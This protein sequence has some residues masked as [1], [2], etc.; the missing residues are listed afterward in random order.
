MQFGPFAFQ[1]SFTLLYVTYFFAG[2]GVGAY[3][4]ERGLLASDG[5]LARRWA[6]WLASAL[7]GFLLWIIPAALTMQPP[8]ANVP[9]LEILADFGLVVSCATACFALAAVFLRFAAARSAVV[10]SLSANAYGIY[11]VHYV[12]VIWLQYLLLGVALFAIAKGAI[13]FAA[14]SLLSWASTAAVCRIPIGARLMRA[15]GGAFA[16]A[17]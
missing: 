1:P 15:R 8:G 16:R 11:L 12:F 17:R 3:G 5:M 13:V 10:D 6:V 9:A 4:L 7:A 2:L 14:A